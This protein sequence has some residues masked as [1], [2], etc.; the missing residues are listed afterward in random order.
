LAKPLTES[1]F[2]ALRAVD[3]A[4]ICNAIEEVEGK[5]RADGFSRRPVVS[6]NPKLPP[7]VGYAR[8]ATIRGGAPSIKPR[9]AARALRLDYYRYVSAPPGPA[10]P[11]IQDLDDEPG[12]GAFWGE[13]N[14]AIHKGLGLAGAL[15]NGSMRD[16]D[17]LAPDF[18][19]IAG[20]VMPSHAHV[21]VEA[22]DVPVTVFGLRINPG[23]II[24]ADRHGA[25]A[26]SAELAAE[27]PRG[28]DLNTRREAP[29][30]KVAR[31]PGFNLEKL[32]AAWGEADDVH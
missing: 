7:I 15:T 25:V 2:G 29:V 30:L 31:A 3:T 6:C 27:V 18:H 1:I 14:T 19:L 4:T 24:H 22:I 10:V 13:V 17:L 20:S 28:I 16:M 9:A 11:V 5:R 23:D 12:I 8:T 21:H 32:L 26:M